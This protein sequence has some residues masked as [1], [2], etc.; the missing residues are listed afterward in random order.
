M[1]LRALALGG[2]D[3]RHVIGNAGKGK[4]LELDCG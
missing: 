1:K 2:I 3:N 4:V